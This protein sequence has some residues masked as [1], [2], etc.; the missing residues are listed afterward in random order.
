MYGRNG[1]RTVVGQP[2]FRGATWRNVAQRHQHK[3]LKC[4]FTDA[5]PQN[6]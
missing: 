4:A 1:S 5:C 3:Q 2:R 6:E